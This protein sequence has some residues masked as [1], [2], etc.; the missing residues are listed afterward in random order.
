MTECRT[1]RFLSS[2]HQEEGYQDE[3]SD[4]TLHYTHQLRNYNKDN[5][6]TTSEV[7][8][9]RNTQFHVRADVKA[10]HLLPWRKCP[11]K[12]RALECVAQR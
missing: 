4:S 2:C 3:L 8:V 6:E 5:S 11:T 10:M 1:T 12:V 7:E 9:I